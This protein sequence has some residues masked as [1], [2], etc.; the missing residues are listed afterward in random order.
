M[1][2]APATR[3]AARRATRLRRRRTLARR[4]RFVVPSHPSRFGKTE[5][6]A[7]K[8]VRAGAAVK[9]RAGIA[10]ARA[11]RR[12]RRLPQYGR[13]P[14]PAQQPAPNHPPRRRRSDAA[15]SRAHDPATAAWRWALHAASERDRTTVSA[16]LDATTESAGGCERPTV[17][18][19][20]SPHFA[21]AHL[22]KCPH[23]CPAHGRSN[24]RAP[25]AYFFSRERAVPT[26]SMQTRYRTLLAPARRRCRMAGRL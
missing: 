5:R 15:P 25:T 10:K 22:Y 12:W 14:T 2:Y 7:G 6:P 11:I 1:P 9:V 23:N 24:R 16:C 4:P 13:R 17:P 3:R 26:L 18:T 20:I 8:A 19:A 21:G